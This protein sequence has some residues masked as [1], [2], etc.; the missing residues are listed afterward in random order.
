MFYLIRIYYWL[1]IAPEIPETIQFSC[2]TLT[3]IIA[4]LILTLLRFPY[5]L[6]SKKNLKISKFKKDLTR[7]SGFLISFWAYIPIMAGILTPMFIFFPIAYSSWQI[8]TFIIGESTYYNSLNSW[9]LIYPWD[10]SLILL[11]V[12]I[13][14]CIFLI[15]LGLFL[16]GFI[17]LLNI[18]MNEGKI[19]KTGPYKYIRHPQNLGILILTLPFTL[20]IPGFEDMGI[21]IADILSWVLFFMI[22]IIICDLEEFHMKRLHGVDYD[23]FRN[24]TGYFFPK[25]RRKQLNIIKNK[26]IIYLIRYF[27]MILAFSII[28][29]ITNAI[30]EFL[31]LNGIVQIFR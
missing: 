10:I 26:A 3:I 25:T 12:F 15:G 31:Y 30:A 9:F 21:R 7:L 20:Y 14:L 23:N 19:A 5:L 8:L 2:S 27:L 4:F 11:L 22:I 17:T 28:V 1:P 6:E 18:R 13:E 16:W 29:Y 24:Q